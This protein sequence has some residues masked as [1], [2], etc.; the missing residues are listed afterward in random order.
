MSAVFVAAVM[1][2]DIITMGPLV[3]TV[4]LPSFESVRYV[5]LGSVLTHIESIFAIILLQLFLFKVSILLYAFVLGLS[6]MLNLKNYRTL[7][8][9]SAALVFFYSLMVF[10]SVMEN[11]DWGASVA[12]FFSLTFEFLLPVISLLVAGLRKP[13]RIREAQA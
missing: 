6:Q 2:H 7:T 8:L 5:S 1:L 13:N 12:P 11:M 9:I 3:S 4:S 10:E